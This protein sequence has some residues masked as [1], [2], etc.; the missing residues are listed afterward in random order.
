V[1]YTVTLL[2]DETREKL[3]V[4]SRGDLP[5]HVALK[6]TAYILWRDQTGGLPLRIE[7]RVGQRHKPDLVAL[8]EL[9]GAVRLW[10]DCGQIET[11]RL[12]RIAAKN[13][14]ARIIVLK[15]SVREAT[16]YAPAARKDLPDPCRAQVEIW[17]LDQAFTDALSAQLRG[18]NT[19]T[20]ERD[21]G[22]LTV[23]V[24]GGPTLTTGLYSEALS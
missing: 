22:T 8:E 16:N 12:G 14:G 19:F 4:E 17:G 9:T 23:Y 6:L 11:E 20:I 18:V 3:V 10:I 24:Q 15:G 1:K 21:E 2:E 7:Q 13:P 5:R